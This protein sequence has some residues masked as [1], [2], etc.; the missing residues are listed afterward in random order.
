M[1]IRAHGPGVKQ[2]RRAD[3]FGLASLAAALSN[4]PC[5][6]KEVA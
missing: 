4:G 2:I 5:L 1:T 6:G 3:V